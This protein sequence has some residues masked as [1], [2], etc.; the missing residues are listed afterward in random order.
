MVMSRISKA[1]AGVLVLAV[2][3]GAAGVQAAGVPFKGTGSGTMTG[4]EI[5]GENHVVLTAVGVGHATHL[6]RYTRLESIHLNPQNGSFTGSIT[7]A[8]ANGDH[9]TTEVSGQFVSLAAA[10]GTYTFTGGTGRFASATGQ[11][12][13]S[14]SLTSAATF[15]FSFDGELAW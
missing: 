10:V 2:A 15:A 9:L 6:G 3:C 13:F 4:Q 8:A 5:L 1:L 7:F 12:A 11:A 14:V